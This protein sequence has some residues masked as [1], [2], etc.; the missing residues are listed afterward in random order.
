MLANWPW[1]SSSM[2][3]PSHRAAR[4]TAVAEGVPARLRCKPPTS[5]E[6]RLG[7]PRSEG[8]PLLLAEVGLAH[9][10][11]LVQVPAGAGQHDLAHLQDITLV[12][13]GERGLGVLLDHQDG[14]ALALQCGD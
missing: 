13:Q 10:L 14:D 8:R 1:S 5:S 3:L 6:Y 4:T 2:L 9:L 11:V 12:R 7:P